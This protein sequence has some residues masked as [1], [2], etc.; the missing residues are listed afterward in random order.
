M[1]RRQEQGGRERDRSHVCVCSYVLVCAYVC[2]QPWQQE[3]DIRASGIRGSCEPRRR[4]CRCRCRESSMGALITHYFSRPQFFCLVSTYRCY[5]CFQIL[6]DCVKSSYFLLSN[7]LR[8]LS[9]CCLWTVDTI[10][11]LLFSNFLFLISLSFFWRREGV[12]AFSFYIFVM[13]S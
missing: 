13:P 4:R 11:S 8:F 6:L 2:K 5:Y 12:D 10:V 7:L 9:V 1:V 3:E